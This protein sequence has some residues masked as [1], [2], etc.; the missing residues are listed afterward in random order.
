MALKG[1]RTWCYF[2]AAQCIVKCEIVSMD[3]QYITVLPPSVQFSDSFKYCIGT[4]LN[5]VQR[6]DRALVGSIS[7]V[8][9]E[10]CDN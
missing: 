3:A 2:K 4:T 10:L 7:S 6:P 5:V 9:V 8:Q 1:A